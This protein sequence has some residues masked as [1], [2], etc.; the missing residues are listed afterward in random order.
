MSKP[1]DRHESAPSNANVV[2]KL[3]L[4]R[5]TVRS[6]N[7]RTRVTTGAAAPPPTGYPCQ[8]S[9][10]PKSTHHDPT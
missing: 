9:K 5:E 3:T 6:L 4:S 8:N 1:N 7:V 2:K 10:G